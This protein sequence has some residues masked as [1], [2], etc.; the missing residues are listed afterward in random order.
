MTEL[1]SLQKTIELLSD[2]DKKLVAGCIMQL[3]KVC[4]AYGEMPSI[5]ALYQVTLEIKEKI[6]KGL[7]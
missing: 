3:K 1:D 5:L 6:E 2:E 4:K 7:V